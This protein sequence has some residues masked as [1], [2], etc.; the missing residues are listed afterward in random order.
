MKGD[1]LDEICLRDSKVNKSKIVI[2][3]ITKID[4]QK[5]KE[6]KTKNIPLV[7]PMCRQM[8]ENRTFSSA[9]CI[10]LFIYHT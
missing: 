2:L 6:A 9:S 10:S 3:I 7:F 1:Q 4:T 5:K 8:I